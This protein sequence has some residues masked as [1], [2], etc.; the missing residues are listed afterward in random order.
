MGVETKFN[1]THRIKCRQRRQHSYPKSHGQRITDISGTEVKT[2][3]TFEVFLTYGANFVHG[4]R[5]FWVVGIAVNE[6]VALLASGAFPRQHAE[7]LVLLPSHASKLKEGHWTFFTSAQESSPL[8][9]PNLVAPPIFCTSHPIASIPR[10]Y[11]P[12]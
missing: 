8:V 4:R 10:A 1:P 3:F 5:L 11:L 12:L 7:N 6:K 9:M 2:R